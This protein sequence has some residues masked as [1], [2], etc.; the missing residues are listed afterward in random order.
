MITVYKHKGI[1]IQVK[2]VAEVHEIGYTINHA[3]FKG[4]RFNLVD[5]AI[6]AIDRI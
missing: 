5:H 6:K 4:Q 2:A 3:A 1:E